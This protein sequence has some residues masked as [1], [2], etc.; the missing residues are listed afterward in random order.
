MSEAFELLCGIAALGDY[1]TTTNSELA[2]LK[3]DSFEM[4]HR[5]LG[6][7]LMGFRFVE[8]GN[9]SRACRPIVLRIIN[10]LTEYEWT[11][12]RAFMTLVATS[13]YLAARNVGW[14]ESRVTW[15]QDMDQTWAFG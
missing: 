2:K 5:R 8:P 4:R 14:R 7:Y 10:G 15:I 9:L 1:T 13:E 11:T 6:H 3:L 12:L